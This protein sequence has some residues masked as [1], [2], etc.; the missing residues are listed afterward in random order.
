MF[1]CDSLQHILLQPNPPSPEKDERISAKRPFARA[2]PRRNRAT[3][4]HRASIIM[5]IIIQAC[6]LNIKGVRMHFRSGNNPPATLRPA[7]P[8]I[9]GAL[10]G[11]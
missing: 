2:F 9:Q 8:F 7:A 11:F 1:P 10:G 3:D 6:V 5:S 4:A